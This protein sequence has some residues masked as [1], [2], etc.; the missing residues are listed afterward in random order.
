MRADPLMAAWTKDIRNWM[1]MWWFIVWKRAVCALQTVSVVPGR[2]F[3]RI[4]TNTF[5]FLVLCVCLC[6]RSNTVGYETSNHPLCCA[7]VSMCEHV[8]TRSCRIASA[9]S[10]LMLTWLMCHQ[11]FVVELCAAWNTAC[12]VHELAEK[13]KQ[14]AQKPAPAAERETHATLVN[15]LKEA[16]RHCGCRSC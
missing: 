6:V 13:L 5:A 14:R 15:L 9:C 11:R 3:N 2:C 1:K 7:A 12:T 10:R 4:S 16:L 8:T